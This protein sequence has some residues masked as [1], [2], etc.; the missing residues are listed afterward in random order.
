M[1]CR[2]F[3]LSEFAHF[4]SFHEF[5]VGAG[6]VNDFFGCDLNDTVGNR[7]HDLVVVRGEDDIALEGR[8]TVINRRDRFEVEVVGR[9]SIRKFEPKS[10]MRENIQRTRSPPESTLTGL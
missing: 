8:Q 7:I 3:P 4:A 2:F 9:S 1:I 10:I 5:L 6:A